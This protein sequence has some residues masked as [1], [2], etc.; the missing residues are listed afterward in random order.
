MFFQSNNFIKGDK[1]TLMID[2]YGNGITEGCA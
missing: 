2:C 1:Y